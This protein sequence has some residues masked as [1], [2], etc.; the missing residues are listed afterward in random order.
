MNTL[1]PHPHDMFS[2][3]RKS[4]ISHYSLIYSYAKEPQDPICFAHYTHKHPLS[5]YWSEPQKNEWCSI[6]IFV[7]GSCDFILGNSIYSPKKGDVILINNNEEYCIQ[8]HST[9]YLD[10]YEINFPRDFFEKTNNLNIFCEPFFNRPHSARNLIN[11]NSADFDT[12]L[13]NLKTID[14]M[15]Q[16]SKTGQDILSYSY[17]IQIMD[18]FYTAFLNLPKD[19]QS[20]Q[21][22]SK[23][24]SALDYIHKNFLTISGVD[25]IAEACDISSS[26]LARIFK[27]HLSTSPNAYI[28]SI[29]ISYA[30]FL[31]RNGSTLVSACYESSFNDYTYFASRFKQVTGKTPSQYKKSLHAELNLQSTL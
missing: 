2:H 14:E 23:L 30:K 20:T 4:D 25:E 19:S 28:S 11:I 12:V 31:I 5:P 10:Y 18:I 13:R 7:S 16:Q 8:I 27:K 26:Y 17:I 6:F 29:R 22:P 1:S 24:I 15:I 3:Y 9:L 21:T